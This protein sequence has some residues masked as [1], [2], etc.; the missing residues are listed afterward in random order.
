MIGFYFPLLIEF[1]KTCLVI[2]MR[3]M[4]FTASQ[5]NLQ[6]QNKRHKAAALIVNLPAGYSAECSHQLYE[7]KNRKNYTLVNHV[8]IDNLTLE[9]ET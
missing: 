8:A 4:A 7:T 5:E 6:I 9:I 2:S 1:F 3:N